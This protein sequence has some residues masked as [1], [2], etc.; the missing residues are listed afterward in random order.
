MQLF[1]QDLKTAV[2]VSAKRLQQQFAAAESA[3][4]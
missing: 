1:A 3:L 2:P 4:A